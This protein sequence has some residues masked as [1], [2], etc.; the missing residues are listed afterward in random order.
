MLKIR[1]LAFCTRMWGATNPARR[2][3]LAF[4]FVYIIVHKLARLP[5]SVPAPN[6]NHVFSNLFVAT[7]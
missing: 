3:Q 4:S 2:A 6:L 7:S 1:C 5:L